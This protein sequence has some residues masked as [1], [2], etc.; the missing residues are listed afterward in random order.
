M[1]T[2][3]A[4]EL[5]V[6]SESEFKVIQEEFSKGIVLMSDFNYD[7]V[8]YCSGVDLAYW[9]EDGEQ[10]GVCS[11]VTI[12][13][14]TCEIVESTWSYGKISV[15]YV[16]SYLAFRELPLIIC[17][18]KKLEIESDIFMF[19]GNGYLHQR[20]MGVATHASFFLNKPTIGVAKSYLKIKEYEYYIPG[21][22][23]G[24][25]TDITID[26]DVYGR[27]LRS[28]RNT[29]PIFISCGNYI[30]IEM[31]TLIVNDLVNANESRLPIPIRL[32]DIESRKMRE[33]L[34]NKD[35][36]LRKY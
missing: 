3:E 11:I 24:A 32:A 17:A 33:K 1:K 26:G 14:K 13:C 7:D 27:V 25:Y 18:V 2:I 19:D 15:D 12:D 6:N 8:K 16:S 31:T 29:K 9:V 28:R 35:C 34:R 30:D 21:K 20:H 10:F 36:I 23:E 5:S 4:H 22:E